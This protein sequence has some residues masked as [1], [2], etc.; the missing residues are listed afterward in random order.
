[1]LIHPHLKAV[2][3][4]VCHRTKGMIEVESIPITRPVLDH[5][6]GLTDPSFNWPSST[7]DDRL[8]LMDFGNFIAALAR[9]RMGNVN[10]R[11]PLL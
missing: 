2:S 4:Y 9:A 1:M 5:V 7:D 6:S 10:P 8:N 11:G 3:L